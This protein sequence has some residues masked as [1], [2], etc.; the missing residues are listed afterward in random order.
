M[1]HMNNSKY[2]LDEHIRPHLVY[3]IE[4]DIPGAWVLKVSALVHLGAKIEEVIHDKHL[5]CLHVQ[6]F[7]ANVLPL[8]HDF[9]ELQ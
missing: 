6:V 5:T 9:V 2:A 4:D 7:D 1:N 8:F 3:V